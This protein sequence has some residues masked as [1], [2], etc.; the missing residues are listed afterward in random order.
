MNSKQLAVVGIELCE[1]G[2]DAECNLVF[3]MPVQ[4]FTL[5]KGQAARLALLSLVSILLVA[6]TQYSRAHYRNLTFTVKT[7]M[8][9]LT[10]LC[11]LS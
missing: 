3:L 1:E 10:G 11:A 8:I 6:L 7:A 9:A 5:R 2:G 4:A